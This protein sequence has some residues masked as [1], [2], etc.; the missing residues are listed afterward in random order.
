MATFF[1]TGTRVRAEAIAVA[2]VMPADGPSFQ[3]GT[4]RYVNMK[5][6]FSD[7]VQTHCQSFRAS[8]DTG[9]RSLRSLLH[10]VT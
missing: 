7:E 3:Y 10:H 2:I 5:V 6:A 9:E 4:L 1:L 8:F